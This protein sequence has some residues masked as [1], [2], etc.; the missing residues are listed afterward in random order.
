VLIEIK[1]WREVAETILL[2]H[3]RGRLKLLLFLLTNNI[4]INSFVDSVEKNK[5]YFLKRSG[6]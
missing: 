4:R 3:K 5:F 1:I 2:L 6:F